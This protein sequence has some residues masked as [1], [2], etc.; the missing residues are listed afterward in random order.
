[1]KSLIGKIVRRKA[2]DG[3]PIGPYLQ[4]IKVRRNMVSAVPLTERKTIFLNNV[5]KCNTTTLSISKEHMQRLVDC[6]TICV[7]HPATPQWDKLVENTPEIIKFVSSTTSDQVICSVDHVVKQW[8]N[9]SHEYV[10]RVI[11]SE[12]L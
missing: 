12:I 4:V 11:I 1:M 2:S 8:S 6:R 10:V 5:Y 3:A 7:E 9:V